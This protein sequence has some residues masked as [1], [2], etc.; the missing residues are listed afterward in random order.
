MVNRFKQFLI[1]N[2]SF[3]DLDFT[4]A[5]LEEKSSWYHF[6]KE[7]ARQD[8]SLGHCLQHHQSARYSV[9]LSNAEDIKSY[10]SCQPNF[11]AIGSNSVKKSTDSCKISNRTI[12]GEKKYISNLGFADFHVLWIGD[13]DEHDVK[14]VFV[15]DKVRGLYKDLSFNPM[16]ME[17]TQT[18]KIIFDSVVDYTVLFSLSDVQHGMRN[19]IQNFSFCTVS[20]GL[21]LG[22]LDDIEQIVIQKKLQLELSIHA[23][24]QEL[25]IFTE[26]WEHLFPSLMMQCYDKTTSHKVHR[27][28]SQLKRMI[29]DLIKV[30]LEIGDSRHTQAGKESQRF[31]DAITYATHRQNYYTS[32]VH[33]Y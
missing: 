28:Y 4:R 12:T 16:G 22:L 33:Y 23:Y 24:R 18:G 29:I 3:V 15:K 25:K 13:D 9:Q 19:H 30:L 6:L 10:L 31:R 32:L 21:C 17:E 11:D 27:I 26:A 1:D 8:L 14:V 20:L 2:N 7:T 5:T